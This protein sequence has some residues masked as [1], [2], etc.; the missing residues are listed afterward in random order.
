M[1]LA[2]Y[3]VTAPGLEAVTAGELA[4][5]GL[6]VAGTEAGGVAF[7]VDRRGLY[8]ANLHLR[9]A[10]RVLVRLASFEAKGF[11]ELERRARTV[12]WDTVLGPGLTPTFRVT[13][14]K[15]RL[16]HQDAIAERLAKVVGA[17][18]D[19]QPQEFVVR[20][21][22]DHFTISADSSGALLHQRG[23][24]FATAKAPL[25]ET[26]AAAM[27]LGAGWDPATPLVDPFC[28]SGTIAIEAALL[29]RKMP[30]G[31]HREFACF[32]WPGFDATAW[33]ALRNEAD[34]AVRAAAPA[35]IVASDRDAGAIRAATANAER[36][37]VLADITFR[38]APLSSL[39]VPPAA[40]LLLT[41]PPYGV[42]V[43]EAAR[44]R[45]LYAS[46][47]ALARRSLPEW[48]V[49]ML[50]ADDRLLAQVGLPW[51]E[52]WRTRNG[53]IPVRLVQA[54]VSPQIETLPPRA[55]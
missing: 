11:A 17:A 52:V 6:A 9:T 10:S 55:A 7:T 31:R 29:A 12:P 8:A 37:G 25:R 35:P 2:C 46:L 4:A 19:G 30:P 48:R 40:G 3:A 16:Y 50:A 26:L 53:G 54:T 51:A 14:K 41:N 5:L 28:G 1:T 49:A 13:S 36:A 20:V 32:R 24:R 38:Q 23:Y 15:S 45:D 42:R 33:R 22:R 39:A 34:A 44:L 21:F 47:G 27:L 43:G 18:P